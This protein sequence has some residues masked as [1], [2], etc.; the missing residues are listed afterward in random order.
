[1]KNIFLF[2]LFLL[3][4]SCDSDSANDCFQTSGK[5]IR[6]EFMV[7][8]F[9]KILVNRNIE[10]VIKQGGSQEVVVETGENLLN[11]ITAVV[12]DSQLILSNSNICN[13]V[14]DYNLTKVYV[15]VPDIKEI[16][17]STQY[18][19]SS[20]GVLIFPSLRIVS[21]NYNDPSIIA[22]GDVNLELNS[23]EIVV[24]ANNL[25]S[26][27]LDGVADKLSVNFYAGDGV[28]NGGG[29]I[30]NSVNV[31][32]RGTNNITVNPQN[33]LEG[34]LVSTGDLIALNKPDNIDVSILYTGD[35]IF[36]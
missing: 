22:V 20:Q 10:L 14:R 28:F 12:R 1:M 5:I 2:L 27:K 32:H 35:L 34:S 26:F 13:F 18:K 30:A 17:S 24:V 15:T 21:E 8:E 19:I 31:Y 3:I 11:D 9:T 7:S 4:V 23:Q 25:T 29:L 6:T 16:I 33:N 36:R